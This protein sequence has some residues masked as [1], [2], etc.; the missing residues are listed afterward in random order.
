VNRWLTL[1]RLLY[2]VGGIAVL[3]ALGVLGAVGGDLREDAEEARANAT[4]TPNLPVD[5]L[6]DCPWGDAS[7]VLALGIERA[8]QTDNVDAVIE[9]MAPRLFICPGGRA[10]GPGGPFPLCDGAQ[11]DD[12]R[13]GLAFGRRYSE[14]GVMSVDGI[15]SMIRRFLDDVDAN[16]RDSV[17][18]GR[19][20]LYAFSCSEPAIRF[21]N[22]SCAREGIVLS[23]IVGRGSSQR[24]ELLIFWAVAGF[25]GKTLPVVEVWDGAILTDEVEVLFETG[26]RLPDLGEVYAIDQALR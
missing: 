6:S 5:S 25:Q 19:L 12:G 23:A 18:D 26:G 1:R 3:V 9:F 8:L 22:V 10:E 11:K 13:T 21:Q 4:P 24:R 2:L 7:C 16:A 15:R 17:G 20:R 14:G